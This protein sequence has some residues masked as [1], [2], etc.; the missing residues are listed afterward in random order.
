VST[1]TIKLLT[2]QALEIARKTIT[3]NAGMLS[4][5]TI[6]IETELGVFILLIRRAA[7]ATS[8]SGKV[9]YLYSYTL[10]YPNFTDISQVGR[11]ALDRINKLN[12]QSVFGNIFADVDGDISI[13]VAILLAAGEFTELK[14][15][16]MASSLTHGAKKLIFGME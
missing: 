8:I 11:N 12:S 16:H 2:E 1:D 3:G 15:A 13:D 7:E 4:D 10:T 14:I 5:N 6:A 9:E